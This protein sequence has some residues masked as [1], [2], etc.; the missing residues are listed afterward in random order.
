MRVEGI[1]SGN[2]NI[3]EVVVDSKGRLYSRTVADSSDEHA[4]NEGRRYGIYSKVINLS[5]AN[6]T[7]VIYFK[8]DENIGIEVTDI[9]VSTGQ[10][11]A[12]TNEILI[13]QVGGIAA[14][15]DIVANGTQVIPTNS[16]LGSA[17]EFSGIVKAGEHAD[18]AIGAAGAVSGVMGVF[19]T[20]ITFPILV[21]IPKGAE[22]GTV[23]TPPVGNTDMDI[24]ITLTFLLLEDI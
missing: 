2:R 23:I 17:N 6:R 19:T 9:T 18:F 21:Q 20:P 1:G 16:N 7:A 24:I 22:V 15:D 13:E 3:N 4:L 10:S 5:T 12:A 11:N 14:T 8:N